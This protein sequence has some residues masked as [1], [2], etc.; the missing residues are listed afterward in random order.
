[1]DKAEYERAHCWEPIDLVKGDDAMTNFRRRARLQQAR[2]RGD[3]PIGTHPIRGGAGARLLGSRLDLDYA[4]R[5]GENFLSA[6]VLESV[7]HRLSYKE[8]HQLLTQ[9][10]LWADLLSSMPMCFNLFGELANDA[11]AANQLVQHLWPRSTARFVELKF[12]WSPGRCDP[13]YLGNKSAF[14]AAF[15]LTETAGGRSVL[16]IET[17]YHERLPKPEDPGSRLERYIEIAERAD[18]FVPGSI[19]SLAH[20]P[21]QQI[22]QDHL[23]VLSMLQHPSASWRKGRFALLYPGG[24]VAYANAAQS[25]RHTLRDDSSFVAMTLED[26]L[27]CRAFRPELRHVFTERYLW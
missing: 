7:R 16:G 3:R 10:R 13:L 20:G 12:E 5:T 2:W 21:L 11:E 8:S 27:S 17:K 9:D 4:R 6:A 15:L 19:D 1:M 14:D 26:V 25:Y 22:W 23:L 18:I 24:N